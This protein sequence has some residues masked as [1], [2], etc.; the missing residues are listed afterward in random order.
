M[1]AMLGGGDKH[2]DVQQSFRLN[3]EQADFLVGGSGIPPSLA[4]DALRD[5][6][7]N[8][9]FNMRLLGATVIG[10]RNDSIRVIFNPPSINGSDLLTDTL[11]LP[12]GGVPGIDKIPFLPLPTPQFTLGTVIGTNL[13]LRWLPTVPMGDLGDFKYFGIGIQHNPQVWM[14][15]KWPVDVSASLFTQNV[16]FG[17]LME[18]STFAMGINASKTFGW[19]ILSA[20]PYTGFALETSTINFGYAYKIDT[21]TGPSKQKIDFDLKGDNKTRLTLGLSLRLLILNINADYNLAKYPSYSLG[22]M[23]GY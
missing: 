17:T 7:M 11:T 9:D 21:P 12:I 4:R 13:I 8:K 10:S 1:G 5:T 23:F 20:T 15:S 3:R 22:L 2:F 16:Q 6:L 19:R 14:G 18:A